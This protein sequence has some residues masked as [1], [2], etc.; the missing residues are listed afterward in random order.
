VQVRWSRDALSDIARLHDFL[1]P[2]SSAAANRAIEALLL[3]PER[4]VDMPSLGTRVEGFTGTEVRRILVL[5]YE[6]RY[7]IRGDELWVVRIFHTRE[8]R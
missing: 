1:S 7:E 5:G 8:D 3:A 2:K 4:L 6:L